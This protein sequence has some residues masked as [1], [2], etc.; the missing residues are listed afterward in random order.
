MALERP[1]KHKNLDVLGR[2]C[3]TASIT[4]GGWR[5]QRGPDAP[6]FDDDGAEE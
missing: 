5:P 6:G 4:A 1:V 3:F 2:Y